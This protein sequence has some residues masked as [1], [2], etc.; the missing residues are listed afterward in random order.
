MGHKANLPNPLRTKLGWP[1]DAR[2]RTPNEQVAK[3]PN[4]ASFQI[5]SWEGWLAPA[6]AQRST[7]IINSSLSFGRERGQASLPNCVNPRCVLSWSVIQLTLS[8]T[9][10]FSPA[11]VAGIFI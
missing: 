5:A 9:G 3:Q 6:R 11:P 7:S 4:A 1:N 8:T 10:R 2:W